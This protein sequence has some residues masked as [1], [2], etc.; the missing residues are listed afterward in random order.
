MKVNDVGTQRSTNK[1]FNVANN[2]LC[3]ISLYNIVFV[4]RCSNIVKW[5]GQSLMA[6]DIQ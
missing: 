3:E 2:I 6:K 1:V 4:L 5:N